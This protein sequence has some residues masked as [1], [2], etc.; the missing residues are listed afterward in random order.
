MITEK[1]SMSKD[2]ELKY[3]SMNS[4]FGSYVI[5]GNFEMLIANFPFCNEN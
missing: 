1:L 4:Y 3:G 5:K 2:L